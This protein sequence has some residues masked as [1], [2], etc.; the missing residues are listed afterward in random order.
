MRKILNYQLFALISTVLF[1]NLVFAE[2][3]TLSSDEFSGQFSKS[4][5]FNSFGCD[6]KNWSPQISWKHPPA[7]TKSFA[8]TLYDPDAPTGSGWWHW[9]VFDI[10]S[11]T[12]ELKPRAGTVENNI[13][14]K[15]AIQ[16]MTSF[17]KVGYGGACPPKGDKPHQYIMTIHALSVDQLGL[18]AS[19]LP[20]LVGFYINQHSIGRS[21]IVAYHAR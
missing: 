6:G 16:S 17:G 8:V 18:D 2:G 15:G 13:A 10:P 5:V 21:S 19:A 1:A 9:V 20:E 4:Q 7:G 3:F 12:R 11:E 14:P